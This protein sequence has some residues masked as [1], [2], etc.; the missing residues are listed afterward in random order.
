MGVLKVFEFTPDNLGSGPALFEWHGNNKYLAIVGVNDKVFILS[1]DGKKEYS[2]TL[3]GTIDLQ[4]DNESD[5]LAII[6]E[7]NT[8]VHLYSHATHELNS[9]D[10]GVRDLSMLQWSRSGSILAIGTE[11]GAFVLYN[12]LTARKIPVVGTHSGC[13]KDAD[14]T[15]VDNKLVMIG[16][17]SMLSVSDGDGNVVFTTRLH[18][19][20]E[21]LV[22]L[23]P[24]RV[25]FTATTN[26]TAVVNER[27]RL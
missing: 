23:Q 25:P 17:D 21:K 6:N 19:D 7:K 12:R 15:V 2:F 14:W 9:F 8:L 13:I 1:H 4:W 10:A 11:K 26:C 5:T 27:N 16:A 22:L 20:A 3:P 24:L 18:R